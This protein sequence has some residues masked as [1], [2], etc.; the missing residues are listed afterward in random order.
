MTVVVCLPFHQNKGVLFKSDCYMMV[1][2]TAEVTLLLLRCSVVTSH[3]DVS[4]FLCS[5]WE[6]RACQ[7]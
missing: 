6:L 1:G 4:P 5:G 2:V 3:L 7:Y